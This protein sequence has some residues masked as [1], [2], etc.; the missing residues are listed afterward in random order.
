MG[1]GSRSGIYVR[2]SDD[3]EGRELGVERQEED[4]RAVLERLG[5]LLVDVYKDNDLGAST[6]SR[7]ARPEYN[8]LLA[9]AR[10]GRIDHVIAYTSSRLTRRPREH[11]DLIELAER[12]GVT[13]SYVRSP[14]F[15][16]NSSAGRRVARILAANDAGEAEDIAERVSRQKQQAQAEGRWIGGR[17]PF[18]FE[19]DGTRPRQIEADAIADATNRILAGD[20]VRSV[21][22]EWNARGL[23]TATGTEWNGSK[24]RQMLMRPRNAGLIGNGDRIIGPASWDPIVPEETWHALVALLKDPER[25]THRGVS[26]RMLGSFMFRCECGEPMM[27][28]GLSAAGKPR[29]RCR[30]DRCQWRIAEPIDRLVLMVVERDLEVNGAN[31]MPA[32]T[33]AAK[34]LRARL[35]ALRVQEQEIAAAFGDPDVPFTAAQFATANRG[36]QEKI[37][38]IEAELGRMQA[39]SVLSGIADAADPVK[40]FRAA[41]QDRQ[42]AIID[43]R[44]SVTL[45]KVGPGRRAFDPESVA[46]KA[47]SE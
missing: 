22:R 33:D 47:K 17:R 28:G 39:G 6:R 43:A 19:A 1:S 42:R 44:W 13:Y 14:S 10:S 5:T 25:L 11:E 45:R 31:L 37:R 29:Y 46:I 30:R 35:N 26:R 3:R 9:D 7:K 4:C 38:A 12:H 40:A 23:L 16:L 27:G 34:P 2:I 32:P 15:D 36:L 18:G 8:R 21:F 20:S 24:M 41:G